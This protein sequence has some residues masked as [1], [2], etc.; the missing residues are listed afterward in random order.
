MPNFAQ[1]DRPVACFLYDE[2]MNLSQ[3]FALRHHGNRKIMPAKP[4]GPPLCAQTVSPPASKRRWVRRPGDCGSGCLLVSN[5]QF[6]RDKF[7]RVDHSVHQ[8]CGSNRLLPTSAS[9][10]PEQLARHVMR[11]RGLPSTGLAPFP[12]RI[13]GVFAI[14]KG[15]HQWPGGFTS[16][17]EGSSLLI[18]P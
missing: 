18:V 15:G 17:V 11:F 5:A 9:A 2:L 3:A 8:T 12:S 16:V 4:V 10:Q 6:S 13:H 7:G 1:S 14:L